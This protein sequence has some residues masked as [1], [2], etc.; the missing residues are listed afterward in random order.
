MGVAVIGPPL[1]TVTVVVTTMC[2]S[3]DT[4]LTFFKHK[5]EDEDRENEKYFG[6]KWNLLPGIP[7]TPLDSV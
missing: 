1:E 2:S 5:P 4:S 7:G 3:A 6:L